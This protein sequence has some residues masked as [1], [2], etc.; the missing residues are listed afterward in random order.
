LLERHNA[1]RRIKVT[2]H[3][4][5]RIGERGALLPAINLPDDSR[6]A[7][8]ALGAPALDDQSMEES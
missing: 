6:E 8:P 1:S 5:R 3:W 4:C 2:A 7:F